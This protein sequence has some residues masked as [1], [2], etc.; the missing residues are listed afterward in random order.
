MSRSVVQWLEQW[1]G[2]Q[3]AWVLFPALLLTC[4]MTLGKSRHCSVPI[5]ALLGRECPSL[6]VYTAPSTM[7]PLSY[8]GSLGTAVTQINNSYWHLTLL[9]A[10]LHDTV[11][12]G[13]GC[14]LERLGQKPSRKQG[15]RGRQMLNHRA[16]RQK[17]WCRQEWDIFKLQQKRLDTFTAPSSRKHKQGHLF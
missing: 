1:T 8:W 9:R 4:L 2:I 15:L 6:C 14:C 3:E 17:I 13:P 10:R 7:G 16:R 12:K 5:S 11:V